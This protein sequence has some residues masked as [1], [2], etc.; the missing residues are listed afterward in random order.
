MPTPA[1]FGRACDRYI[2][3]WRFLSDVFSKNGTGK[4]SADFLGLSCGAAARRKD[5]WFQFHLIV[6]NTFTE[7]LCAFFCWRSTVKTLTNP[8]LSCVVFKGL[9]RILRIGQKTHENPVRLECTPTGLA[10]NFR[11]IKQ[12]ET[13]HRHAGYDVWRGFEPSRSLGAVPLNTSPLWT[14]FHKNQLLRIKADLFRTLN[15]SL[16]DHRINGLGSG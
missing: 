7:L 8:L 13:I 12:P 10:V 6:I 4:A 16:F 15:K 5:P 11:N 3:L 2:C 9:R 14:L 1:V